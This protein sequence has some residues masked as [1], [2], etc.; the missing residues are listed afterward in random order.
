MLTDF[1][2]KPE[3]KRRLLG[4]VGLAVTV[5]LIS[6]FTEMGRENVDRITLSG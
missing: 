3:T 1:F 4:D 6:D 5:I 2:G